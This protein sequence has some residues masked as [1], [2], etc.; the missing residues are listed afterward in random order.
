VVGALT[1]LTP[2]QTAG[3]YLAGVMLRPMAE[4]R[5]K[6]LLGRIGLPVGHLSKLITGKDFCG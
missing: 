3:N 1:V 6:S 2:Q 5:R 4:S